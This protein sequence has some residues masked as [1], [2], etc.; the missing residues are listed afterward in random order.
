M[1][2][3]KIFVLYLADISLNMVVKSMQMAGFYSIRDWNL[4]RIG[5]KA[6]GER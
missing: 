6:A 5:I 3:D 4:R 2:I 1:A